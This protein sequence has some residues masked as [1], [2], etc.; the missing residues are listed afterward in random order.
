MRR[1]HNATQ[2][3]GSA[4]DDGK[5]ASGAVAGAGKAAVGAGVVATVAA[6]LE[7][8][9]EVFQ[10]YPDGADKVIVL[11]LILMIGLVAMTWVK[12]R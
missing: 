8:L 5:R 1:N 10:K 7:V 3:D 4:V 6:K 11:V 12:N 2:E 9:P